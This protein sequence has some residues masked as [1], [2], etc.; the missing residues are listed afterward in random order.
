MSNNITWKEKFSKNINLN[1]LYIENSWKPIFNK[2]M[3]DNKFKTIE[4]FLN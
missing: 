2:L 3:N 4:D 1:E